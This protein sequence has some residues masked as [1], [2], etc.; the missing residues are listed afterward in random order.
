[1]G[2]A[3]NT[4]L[5]V[6][7]IFGLQPATALGQV[8]GDGETTFT[9]PLRANHGLSAKLEADDDEIQLT[10]RKGRQE[11]VYS[12]RGEVSREAISVHFGDLGEF[13][14][15]YRPFRALETH[16][17]NRHCEGE[18]ASTTEGFLRGTMRFHG[19]GDY[20][21]I[22]ADRVKGT[23]VLQP[24]WNCDYGSSR[25]SRARETAA[26]EDEA[27]LG[28]YSRRDSIGFGVFASREADEKPSTFFFASSQEVRDGVT[29]SRD[30]YAGT[31]SAGFAFDNGRG[32][33]FVDPPAPFAGFARYLRR[34]HARDAWSGP[35]TVPLLGLGRVHLAGPGFVAR[36]VPRLPDF[37]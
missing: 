35:L 24:E 32:S 10:V 28:A 4:L 19:E 33:A 36:M 16:G 5:L 8:D 29:I 13:V 23:L 9:V 37:E 22:E 31:R 12:A 25:A 27:T 14:A 34:P 7:L 30:T 21:R 20:V 6:L 3:P 1:M 26:D 15:S 11:A 18:P 17:P 2:R